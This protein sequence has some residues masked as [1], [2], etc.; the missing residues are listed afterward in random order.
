MKRQP[1][2]DGLRQAITEA[3][4]SYL[5]L[6]HRTGVHR[7]SIGRFMRGE[8][9]LRLDIADILADYLGLRVMKPKRK[10]D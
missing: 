2:A 3:G 4:L 7:G 9:S 1:F 8:R 10:A 5:E 6:E